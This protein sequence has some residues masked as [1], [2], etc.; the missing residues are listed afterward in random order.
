M[1]DN[2]FVFESKEDEVPFINAIMYETCVDLHQSIEQLKKLTNPSEIQKNL[3]A[4]NAQQNKE[5]R[6]LVEKVIDTKAIIMDLKSDT[7]E[8]IIHELVDQL[9]KDGHLLDKEL[10]CKDILDRES[11]ISTCMQNGVA[12]PHGRTDGTKEL[13][14]AVGI[15]K[16]GYQFDSIDGKPTK[17]F[18]LCLS[19]KNSTGPHI[20]FISAIASMLNK[21]ESVDEILEATTPEGVLNV[22]INKKK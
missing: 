21:Q 10:C 2:T 4:T 13:V 18:I 16:A 17:I 8:G 5:E 22:L 19:P 11:V 9:A 3:L 6:S 7:K 12:L 1:K 15:H 14:A 20:Q